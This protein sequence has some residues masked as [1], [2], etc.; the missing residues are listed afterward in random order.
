MLASR[1][2]LVQQDIEIDRGDFVSAA[3]CIMARKASQTDSDS[4]QGL[5]ASALSTQ[6]CSSQRK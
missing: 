4:E 6:R 3:Q 5:Q 2:A 1:Q